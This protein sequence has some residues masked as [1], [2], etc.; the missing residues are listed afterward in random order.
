MEFGSRKMK[1]EAPLPTL[2]LAFD[3]NRLE[4]HANRE[5]AAALAV[6]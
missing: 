5:A 3:V 4:L 2:T 6:W 1:R